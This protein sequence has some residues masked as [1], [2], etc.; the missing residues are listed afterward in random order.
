MT[1][2]EFFKKN[3]PQYVT[4]KGKCLSPFW[5]L[6]SAG[7]ETGKDEAEAI[8][9]DLLSVESSISPVEILK[10]IEVIERAEQFLKEE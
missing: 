2:E 10:K 4:E 1:D 9:K 6:F 3:F 5:D 7:Y 8:I